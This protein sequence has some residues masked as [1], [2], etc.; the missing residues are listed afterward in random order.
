MKKKK[1]LKNI[2]KTNREFNLKYRT[3]NIN[4]KKEK[5]RQFSINK[6]HLS[7]RHGYID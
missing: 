5:K 6:R 1:K 7:A 2:K 4:K 3:E